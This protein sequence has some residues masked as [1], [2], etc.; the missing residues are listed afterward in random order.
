[1]FP[2]VR[3]AGVPGPGRAVSV[4]KDECGMATYCGG[5]QRV[6]QPSRVLKC[7]VYMQGYLLC[8]HRMSV[9]SDLDNE[10]LRFE[11]SCSQAAEV[12]PSTG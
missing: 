4:Y 1:M 2:S 3:S 6:T 11:K 9:G 12:F 7:R 10:S 8:N 5:D